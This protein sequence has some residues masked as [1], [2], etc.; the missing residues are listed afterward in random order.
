MRKAKTLSALLWM[1]LFAAGMQAQTGDGGKKGDVAGGPPANTVQDTG[2]PPD[3]VIGPDDVLKVSV[4]KEPDLTETLPV[5]PDGKIS[6]PLLND[7]PAAGLTPLQLKDSITE[8]LK[9]YI[10]NPSVTVVVTGMNSRRVFVSGEVV[11]SGP[12]PLLP[13]MTV[14]QALSEAG[15]NQFANVKGIYILRIENG[16]QEKMPFNYKKVVKGLDPDKNIEL[17]PG[18]TI[19]VP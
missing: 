8:K 4:W 10:S 14:L 6:M 17:K 7:I 12:M 5:R 19:V 15:F 16:K 2:A 1:F 9:K 11:K 3:Y 18:D 13:H